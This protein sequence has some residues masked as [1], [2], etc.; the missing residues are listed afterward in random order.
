LLEKRLLVETCGTKVVHFVPL[1][2]TVRNKVSAMIFSLK[3]LFLTVI[4][5]GM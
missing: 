1:K 5:R 3:T 4:S 2:I